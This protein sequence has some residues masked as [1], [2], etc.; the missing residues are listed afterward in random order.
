MH[1]THKIISDPIVN[2]KCNHLNLK[3]GIH[4]DRLIFDYNPTSYGWYVGFH[5][6]HVIWVMVSDCIIIPQWQYVFFSKEAI[7]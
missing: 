5:V 2:A 6:Q 3:S 4:F 7:G 1:I